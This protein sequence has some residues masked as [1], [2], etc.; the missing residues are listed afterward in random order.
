MTE[1]GTTNRNRNGL[2]LACFQRHSLETLQFLYRTFQLRRGARYIYLCHLFG[3]GLRLIGEDE[4]NIESLIRRHHLEVTILEL[5][6]GESE[7]EGLGHRYLLIIVPAITYQSFFG[8][9]GNKLL[10]ALVAAVTGDIYKNI[11]L[12]VVLYLL[13]I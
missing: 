3:S 8:I 11:I 5:R 2:P 6:I 1:I 7:S 4:L 9:V 10:A 12:I 13:W